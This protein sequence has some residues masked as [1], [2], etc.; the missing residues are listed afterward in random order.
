MSD[1]TVPLISDDDYYSSEGSTEAEGIHWASFNQYHPHQALEAQSRIHARTKHPTMS[2]YSSQFRIVLVGKTGSGKSSTGNTILNRNAFGVVKISAYGV[3]TTSQKEEG[4]V[5]EKKVSVIDTPGIFDPSITEE[6]LRSEIIN[7]IYLS[8]PGPHVFLVVI[9]LDVRITEEEKNTVRWIQMNFGEDAARYTIVLFTHADELDGKSLSDHMR[10]SNALQALVDNCG[11]RCHSFNSRDKTNRSQVTQLLWRIEKMVKENGGDH[12]TNK[13]FQ[14]AQRK[15]QIRMFW[16]G[17]PRIVLLGKTGSGKTATL[18][19]ILKCHSPNSATTTCEE[20]RLNVNGKNVKIIDTPGLFETSKKMKVN[21]EIK[22]LFCMSDPAPCV[23]LL[24]IK[25]DGKSTK[26]NMVKWIQENF[27]EDAVKYTII[28]FTHEDQLKGKALN[29]HFRMRS[30]LQTLVHCC[31]GRCHSFNNKDTENCSQV[32]QLLK[33]IK[34]MVEENGGDHYT[35]DMFQQAQ[36]K[37][38]IRRFWS[39]KPSIVLLGKS[40]AGKTALRKN[41]QRK[42]G[43]SPNSPTETCKKHKA[44][45][46]GKDIRIIDTPG[47]FEETDKLRSEI[48]K[49][50]KLSFP[51]PHVFLLVIRVD[52]RIT[53]EEKILEQWILENI[54]KDAAPYTIILFTHVDQL[55]DKTL[56]EC[57]TERSDLQAL[58]SSCGGRYHTFNSTDRENQHQVAELL[59]KIETLAEG[60][61]WKYFTNDKLKEFVKSKINFERLKATLGGVGGVAGMIA[62]GVVLGVTEFIAAPAVAVAVGVV[63]IGAA[64]VYTYRKITQ[65]RKKTSWDYFANS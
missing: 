52:V 56:D 12:Y 45:V 47:R 40:G 39:L 23:F 43:K 36:R 1:D 13:M 19:N 22:K 41:I 65:W 53:D 11:G 64:G 62:G 44:N 20:R 28:L 37:I 25:L 63:V 9:R 38:K 54:G 26:V 58:V 57:I 21:A 4:M 46:Y 15:I 5:D 34:T 24:V 32:T 3:T 17:K 55:R 50:V 7:C 59:E 49:C 2:T 16:S 60:N 8:A 51:G 6:T 29:E 14:K 35:N 61:K 42:D 31:G 10:D 27:G 33:K 18:K 30:N 48:K